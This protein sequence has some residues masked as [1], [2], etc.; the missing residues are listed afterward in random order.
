MFKRKK[1]TAGLLAAAMLIGAGVMP[2]SGIIANTAITASAQDDWA[3]MPDISALF[4]RNIIDRGYDGR[5]LQ[6]EYAVGE[7]I[8]F[9]FYDYDGDRE[10][11]VEV[12]DSDIGELS[13]AYDDFEYG[14]KGKLVLKK[15]G[16]LTLSAQIKDKPDTKVEYTFDVKPASEV[17]GQ[18]I[19]TGTTCTQT[20]AR[21]NWNRVENADGYR[22]YR[23]T[24]ENE[25]SNWEKVVTIHDGD[26]TTYRDAQAELGNRYKIAAYRKI[27][28]K[29]EWGQDSM[30]VI[31]TLKP[32]PIEV[33]KSGRTKDAARIYWKENGYSS[34]IKIQQYDE[35]EG[36]WKTIKTLGSWR[37]NYRIN[38]LESGKTYKFRIQAYTRVSY[39][40]NLREG[41]YYSAWSKPY[42]VTTK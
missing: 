29:T 34:G 12:S 41:T 24:Y 11:T 16:K 14:Y 1:L 10:V 27:D 3:N 20:A 31:V 13:Y 32:K 28:G 19:I 8:Y 37:H 15:E 2:Q 22:I 39:Y 21:L 17:L 35:K 30:E 9:V 25:D 23:Y 36:K 33:Y 40:Y 5:E 18:P 6:S 7:V 42:T 4:A 38:G 26:I